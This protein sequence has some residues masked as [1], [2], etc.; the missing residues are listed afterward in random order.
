MHKSPIIFTD[1]SWKKAICDNLEL[2]IEFGE[3]T[4]RV[5]LQKYSGLRFYGYE[6][7]ANGKSQPAGGCKRPLCRLFTVC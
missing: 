1:L 2:F 4:L 3:Q 5:A 6:G 7:H